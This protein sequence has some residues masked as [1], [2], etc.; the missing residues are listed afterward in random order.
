MFVVTL[1]SVAEVSMCIYHC[2]IYMYQYVYFFIILDLHLMDNFLWLIM[3]FCV[4][5]KFAVVLINLATYS[6]IFSESLVW[7]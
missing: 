4:D 5:P 2:S 6:V 7:D 3:V 1:F